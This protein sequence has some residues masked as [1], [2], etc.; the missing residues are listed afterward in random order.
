MALVSDRCPNQSPDGRVLAEADDIE[1][2]MLTN[3]LIIER[4]EETQTPGRSPTASASVAYNPTE[5][6]TPS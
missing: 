4:V 2:G 1:P 5:I 3:S 6:P